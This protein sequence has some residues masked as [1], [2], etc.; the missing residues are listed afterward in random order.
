MLVGGGES[1][2]WLSLIGSRPVTKR[3]LSPWLLLP[4]LLCLSHK[5]GACSATQ[6]YGDMLAATGPNQWA[7]SQNKL[8][9]FYIHLSQVVSTVTH[10]KHCGRR[11]ALPT[12]GGPGLRP[13]P[14]P[15]TQLWPYLLGRPHHLPSHRHVTQA[16]HSGPSPSA[17]AMGETPVRELWAGQSGAASSFPHGL[18]QARLKRSSR[19][20]TWNR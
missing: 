18:S 15:G 8:L 3:T 12:W 13:H 14:T 1:F 6:P 19:S 9:L 17:H 20:E 4:S 11:Q 7:P 5:V 2:R 16:G 10:T